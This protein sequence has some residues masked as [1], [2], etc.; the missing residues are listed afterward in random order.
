M[1]NVESLSSII[2]RGGRSAWPA[3]SVHTSLSFFA[4]S[5]TT[6]LVLGSPNTNFV[7]TLNPICHIFSDLLDHLNSATHL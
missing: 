7:V 5:K 1:K 6:G 4:C 2:P 3:A